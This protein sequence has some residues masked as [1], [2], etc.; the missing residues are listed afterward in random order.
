MRYAD[1]FV[2]CFQYKEDAERLLLAAHLG[3]IKLSLRST[4]DEGK[5]VPSGTSLADL[6]RPDGLGIPGTQRSEGEVLQFLNSMPSASQPTAPSNEF[7]MH[8]MSSR[9]QITTYTWS[10]RNQLP[11]ELNPTTAATGD[12]LGIASPFSTFP[13]ESSSPP[14]AD[15]G[16]EGVVADDAQPTTDDAPTAD[17]LLD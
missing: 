5:D 14:A 9:G 12:G 4:D 10:D 1:D 7:Q 15:D 3:D 17:G 2:C 16:N 13:A 6:Q 11:N 8:V